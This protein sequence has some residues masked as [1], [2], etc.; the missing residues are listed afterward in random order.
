MV[1]V[2]A[3][4]LLLRHDSEVTFL[5]I[6]KGAQHQRLRQLV[7]DWGLSNC[8]FLPYQDLEDLAHSLLQQI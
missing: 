6:G 8:I 3:A 7:H 4:A 1:T 5:F 2:M